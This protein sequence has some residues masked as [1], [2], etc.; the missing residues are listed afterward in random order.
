MFFNLAQSCLCLYE[1][2]SPGSNSISCTPS[3]INMQSFL[4][5]VSMPTYAPLTTAY[6]LVTAFC[7]ISF[8][9]LQPVYLWW[10]QQ[11]YLCVTAPSEILCMPVIKPQGPIATSWWLSTQSP[12]ALITW[13]LVLLLINWSTRHSLGYMIAVVNPNTDHWFQ[14]SLTIW[15]L[16]LLIQLLSISTPSSPAQPLF[17]PSWL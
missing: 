1:W 15:N 7:S 4:S 6:L 9:S 13:W 16:L 2:K 10:H 8:C 12:V 5:C 14:L 17:D 3:V 11:W